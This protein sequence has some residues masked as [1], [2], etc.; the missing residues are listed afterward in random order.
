MSKKILIGVLIVVIFAV[1]AYV[2]YRVLTSR[3]LS[4]S[5]TT[6]YSYNGL[7]L[8]LVYCRPFKKG[9]LIFGEAKDSALVQNGKY[10]R[11][12]ANEATEI[13]FSKNINFAGKPLK[14][15]SYRMYAIPNELS[16]GISFNSELGKWGYDE[17]NYSLDVLKVDVPVETVPSETEQFTIT[18]SSDAAGVNM[19]LA[20]DKTHLRVPIAV[21]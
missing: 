11:L 3:Q 13:T 17:P 4:P 1:I 10:W 15:G 2:A 9:R 7:D 16:W 6:T 8:K 5:Q 14:A 20:W 19:D 12:G 18:F 21:Q